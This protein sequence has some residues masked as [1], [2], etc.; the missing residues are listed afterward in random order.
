MFCYSRGR[1]A[2]MLK[3]ADFSGSPEGVSKEVLSDEETQGVIDERVG[4]NDS[5]LGCAAKHPR[6]SRRTKRGG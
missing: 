6:R 5:E 1:G 3:M 2:G 4:A